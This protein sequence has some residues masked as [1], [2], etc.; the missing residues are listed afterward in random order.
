MVDEARAEGDLVARLNE[1]GTLQDHAIVGLA[2][3]VLR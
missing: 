2:T 1:T 3:I